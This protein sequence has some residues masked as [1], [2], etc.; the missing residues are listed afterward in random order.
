[1]LIRKP[2][3]LGGLLAALIL[4]PTTGLFAQRKLPPVQPRAVEPPAARVQPN[5]NTRP[6]TPQ[7]Q[8]RQMLNLPAPW[9]QRLQNMTPEQQEKFLTNNARF[10]NMMPQQQAQIR[11]RLQVWNSLTPEQRQAMQR[12]EQLLNQLTPEQQ[13]FVRQTLSPE[14]RNLR[15]ARRQAILNRLR[16]LRGLDDAQRAEKLKDEAFLGD[17]NPDERQILQQMSELRLGE[18]GAPGGF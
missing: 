5:P 18:Q 6:L 14:W 10:Q 17:L 12:N 2:L 1:M 4:A 8:A 11:Q 16:D 9:V 7:A 13:R 3:Q 15:P